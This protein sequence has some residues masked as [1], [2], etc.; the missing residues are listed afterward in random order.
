MGLEI[1]GEF[2]I[3][4]KKIVENHNQKQVWT[5]VITSERAEQFGEYPAAYYEHGDEA[6]TRTVGLLKLIDGAKAERLAEIRDNA[7]QPANKQ[8]R[9]YRLS[10]EDVKQMYELIKEMPSK[11]DLIADW[12][13][14]LLPE[15]EE[16]I[17]K[18]DPNLYHTW[19]SGEKHIDM[20]AAQTEQLI[21]FLEL[22]IK[23]KREVWLSY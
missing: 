10:L 5:S 8:E 2:T 18:I 7:V 4:E 23:T 6:I 22:A 20:S 1:I 11:W 19:E 17:D 9:G 15:F 12:S 13:W 3:E 14:Q 16:V 21:K